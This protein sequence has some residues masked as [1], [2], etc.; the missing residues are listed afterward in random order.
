MN[1][2][3]WSFEHEGRGD[4]TAAMERVKD[5]GETVTKT[6]VENVKVETAEAV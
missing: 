2:G 6:A 1:A 5:S 3:H 4:T